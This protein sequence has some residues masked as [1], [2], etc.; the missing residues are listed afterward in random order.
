ML[1]TQWACNHFLYKNLNLPK[2]YEVSFVGR[3]YGERKNFVETIKK[4]GINV[5]TFGQ[6]WGDSGRVSQ[7]ELI[8]IYNESKITLNISLASAGSRIQ[9]KGRDFEAVGCG[10]LLLTKDSKEIAEYFV[11]GEEIVTYK[12]ANDASEKIRDY[13]TRMNAAKESNLKGVVRDLERYILAEEK[14]GNK[15][16][17]N[18]T[19]LGVAMGLVG[20]DIEILNKVLRE[21]FGA[22]ETGEDPLHPARTT[23][24]IAK[25]NHRRMANLL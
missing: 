2:K 24:R 11:P 6:G 5:A 18:T 14:A 16:M 23:N 10:S 15:L 13:L 12:D 25:A 21:H 22:G 1:L 20:Y 19:A 8:K 9:I 7:A 4:K 17:A 3:C